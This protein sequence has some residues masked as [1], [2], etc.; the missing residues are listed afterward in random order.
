MCK[1]HDNTRDAFTESITDISK[2]MINSNNT[3]DRDQVISPCFD[4]RENH[5]NRH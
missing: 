1:F 3:V 2:Y 5:T 4:L